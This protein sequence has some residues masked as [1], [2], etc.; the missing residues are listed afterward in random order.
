MELRSG[1]VL[2]SPASLSLEQQDAHFREGLR[3]IFSK[4]TALQLAVSNQW[5]GRNSED[6]ARQILEGLVGWCYRKRGKKQTVSPYLVLTVVRCLRRFG[7]RQAVPTHTPRFIV[8]LSIDE[9]H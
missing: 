4:W 9:P 8:K 7:F 3:L 5:G 6:K 2:P 1:A